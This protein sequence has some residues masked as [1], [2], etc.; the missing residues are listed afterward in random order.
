MT[1]AEDG[2]KA[3]FKGATGRAILIGPLFGIVQLTYTFLPM[4]APNLVPKAK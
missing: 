4:L 2:V 1:Y 3:L